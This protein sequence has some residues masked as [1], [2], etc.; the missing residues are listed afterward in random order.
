MKIN[1]L[2][3][4]DEGTPITCE[5]DEQCN[6]AGCVLDEVNYGS[7]HEPRFVSAYICDKCEAYFPLEE[8]RWTTL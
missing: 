8:D 1:V 2:Y 7:F 4:L 3:Q 6:H 5:Y